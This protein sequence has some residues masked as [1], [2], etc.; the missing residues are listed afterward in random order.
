MHRII[1]GAA[2]LHY[3]LIVFM[4]DGCSNSTIITD[5]VILPLL[6]CVDSVLGE[7][8]TGEVVR[9]FVESAVVRMTWCV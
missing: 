4:D 2:R 6:G 7:R 9:L 1:S 8:E 5:I 3:G